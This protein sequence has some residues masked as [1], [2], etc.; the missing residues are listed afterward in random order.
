MEKLVTKYEETA[1]EIADKIQASPELEAY[2]DTEEF[3]EYKALIEAYEPEIQEL[4]LTVADENPLQLIALEE[5]LIQPEF[6]GLYI[7][8][9]I[10]YTVLRGQVN[11]NYKYVKPQDHFK[12]ILLAIAQS[13]NFEMIKARVGQS[14][15]MGFALSSDIWITNITDSISNSRVKYFFQSQKVDKYR[16]VVNRKSGLFKYRKQFESLNFYTADF[17]SSVAELKSDFPGLRAFLVERGKGNYDNSS[18]NSHINAFIKN[19]DFKSEEEYLRIILIVALYYDLDAEGQKAFADAFAFMKKHNENLNEEYF[20]VFYEL[21]ESDEIRI[22]PEDDKRLSK[23]INGKATDDINLYYALMNTIHDKGFVH[24][25]SIEAVQD[26]YSQHEGLS[27]NNECL[28]AGILNYFEQL[29]EN[30]PP[31]SYHDYFELNK[32]FVQYINIFGNQKFNQSVKDLSL[33]YI[34]K[35]LKHFTDKRGKDY[36]DI[37]KFVTATFLDLNFMSEKELKELFKTKRKKK[38]TTR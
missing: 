15:Q 38:P 2:L 16:N 6:E 3:E 27:I 35:L 22:T 10:G 21:V 7:P 20:E 1:K 32:T 37:K 36:Q 24:P 29:M 34:K 18:L 28:R 14:V 13:S 25:D 5:Y 11:T 26:Y 33:K 23:L 9:I 30:L 19:D 8:K 12:T 17:P 31:E 4:Y